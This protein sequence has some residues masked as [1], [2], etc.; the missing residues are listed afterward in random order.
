MIRDWINRQIFALGRHVAPRLGPA[1]VRG[2]GRA[3]Y[4]GARLDHTHLETYRH[5]L[6]IVLGREPDETLLRAGIA[7]WVRTYVEVLALPA[8]SRDEVLDR[9]VTVGERHFR[10]AMAGPGAVV[11]L[12]HLGNWDLAGAWACLS[13]FPVTT[14]AENLGPREFAAFSAIRGRLGME[15]VAHDD[16]GALGELVGAVRRGRLVCLLSDRDLAGTG[17]PVRFADRIVTMP[18][19]PALVA[20]RTGAT[21][22]AAAGR[23]TDDGMVLE[24][25]APISARPGRAGLIAM[26]Q[27]IADFFLDQVRRAPA[28]WHM[29][30]PFFDPGAVGRRGTAATAARPAGDG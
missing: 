5:N 16:P 29:L 6:R 28:D 2:L 15:V 25:S 20:R 24:I 4:F 23:Y 9:V 3:A 13:G 7:S 1:A 11:A 26:T 12:P 30:Q 8:W 21:L 22:L 19:G 17:L 10:G 27:D 14:V 18:S